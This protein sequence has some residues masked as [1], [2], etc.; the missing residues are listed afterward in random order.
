MKL[1]FLS[2]TFK[3]LFLFTCYFEL[4]PFLIKRAICNN[5]VTKELI[6]VI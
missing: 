1:N 2:Y 3:E 5:K 4:R 6:A